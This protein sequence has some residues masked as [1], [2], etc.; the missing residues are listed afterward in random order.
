MCERLDVIC[1]YVVLHR[2]SLNKVF[3]IFCVC[4]EQWWPETEPYSTLR[5]SAA[6]LEVS[7]GVLKIGLA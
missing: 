7:V 3:H 2:K 1:I 5:M 6:A 4:N